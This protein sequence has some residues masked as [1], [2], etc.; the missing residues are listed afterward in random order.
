M[1]SFCMGIR[2]LCRLIV[3]LVLTATLAACSTLDVRGAYAVKK[4]KPTDIDP[5]TAR[6]AVIWPE[7]FGAETITLSWTVTEDETLIRKEQYELRTMTPALIEGIKRP[8]GDNLGPVTVYALPNTDVE[9]ATVFQDWAES[10]MNRT[11]RNDR[12]I[13]FSFFFPLKSE[14]DT[15]ISNYCDPSEDAPIYIWYKYR[16]DQP[17]RRIVRTKSIDKFLGDSIYN[18]LCPEAKRT[19]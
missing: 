11:D 3:I 12:L 9:S 5:R 8:R 17:Y 18:I 10:E 6:L 1:Y 16:A 13:S 15:P 2:N 4:L 14:M 7:G 19:Q